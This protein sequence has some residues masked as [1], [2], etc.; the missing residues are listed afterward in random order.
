MRKEVFELI[1]KEGVYIAA[2]FL[3]VL[4]I[5]KIA[6]YK[7][8]IIVLLRTA[9]SIFWLFLLPGYFMMLY[10]HEKLNF[11]E[12]SIIGAIIAA[13]AI[14]IASYYL[15]I[16]GVNVKHHTFLLPLLFIASGFIAALLRKSSHIPQ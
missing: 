7:E 1:K 8:A 16:F 6:F 2:L 9:A 3:T 5:F 11:L 10:W 14:G 15:G 4:A 13:S 12:R